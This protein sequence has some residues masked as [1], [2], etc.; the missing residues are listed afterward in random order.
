[1]RIHSLADLPFS[2]LHQAFLQAFANYAVPTDFDESTLRRLFDRRGGDLTHSVGAFD[3]DD[4]VAFMAVA[5][6]DFEGVRSAYDVFTGALPSHQGQ[7]LAG[8]L[9]EAARETLV[10]AGVERFVLEVIRDNEPAVKAYR[11]QGF[12]VKRGLSCF[13]VKEVDLDT[14]GILVEEVAFEVGESF[15]A[16]RDWNPSWQNSDASLRRARGEV[17]TLVAR[18]EGTVAGCARC[19]PASRDLPQLV[20]RRACRRRG[21]GTALLRACLERTD[22]PEPLRVI[23]VDADSASDLGFYGRWG[24]PNLPSQY[25]MVLAMNAK[26]EPTDTRP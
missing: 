11:K 16:E 24:E 18:L 17:V 12:E 7:G 8:K 20:V 6:E 21:V 19:L 23:N 1:M 9:F 25:E 26:E 3:G 15:A 2:R 10:T 22:S 4:L 13:E 5:V 14:P